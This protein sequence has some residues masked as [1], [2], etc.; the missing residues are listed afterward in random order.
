MKKL[1]ILLIALFTMLS[2]ST[3]RYLSVNT[4][5][6]QSNAVAV[7]YQSYPNLVRYYEEGVLKITSLREIPL[8]D[9]TCDYKIDYKFVKYHYYDYSERMNCLRTK[10]PEIYEMYKFGAV[11]I[12]SLYKYV[13]LNTMEIRHHISYRRGYDYYYPS[14]VYV[15]PHV[16]YRMYYRPSPPPPPRPAHRPSPRPSPSHGHS[17]G[18]HGHRR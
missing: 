7:L 1:V 6:G 10:F 5:E 13:D 12:S 16:R 18:G 14:H 8:S 2:C 15:Y 4:V 3:G 17:S 11:E 9:G